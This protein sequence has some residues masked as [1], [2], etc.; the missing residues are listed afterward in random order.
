MCTSRDRPTLDPVKSSN[1]EVN[2]MVTRRLLGALAVVTL[3]LFAAAGLL[4]N[5][6]HGA[7]GV[8]SDIAWLGF[9]IC[10]L[11]LV[12]ASATVIMRSR[13]RLRRE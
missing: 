13:A 2:K 1:E 12:V 4:G 5:H 8:L 7:V 11:L 6:N 3:V 10:L 9:L